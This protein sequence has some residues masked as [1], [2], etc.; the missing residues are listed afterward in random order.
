MKSERICF[1][2][3][4]L[5][6]ERLTFRQIR[7]EDVDSVFAYKSDPPDSTF[8]RVERHT[9]QRTTQV[10]IQDCLK[11]YYQQRGIT[12][13]LCLRGTDSPIGHVSI[14]SMERADQVQ[15]HRAEIS[16]FL[17]RQHRRTGIMFEARCRIISFYFDKHPGLIR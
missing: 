6:T 17:A 10:F 13:V 14:S 9:D 7:Q 3:P 16:C 11:A 15:P 4:A 1:N 8:P 2:F 5:E 12:W